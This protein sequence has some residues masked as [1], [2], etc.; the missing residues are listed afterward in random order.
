MPE[1]SQYLD[2]AKAAQNIRSDRGLSAA[3]GLN[4]G[5]VNHWRQGRALPAED[6]IVALAQLAGMDPAEAL[7]NLSVWKAGETTKPHWTALK[8][9]YKAAMIALAMPPP[10]L[11]GLLFTIQQGGNI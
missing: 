4:P 7:L 6:T 10:L 5:V 1:L 9:S 8:D 3:L 2:T 11:F